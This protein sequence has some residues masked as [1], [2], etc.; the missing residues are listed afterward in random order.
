MD[1]QELITRGR[2][3]FS[4]APGRLDVFQAVNGKRN[5][6]DIAELLGRHANSIR[7]DLKMIEDAELIQAVFQSD[8]VKKKDGFPIYE[9]IPLSRTVNTRYFR[10]PQRISKPYGPVVLRPPKASEGSGSPKPLAMPS[11]SEVL[12]IARYGE[13][14]LHEFKAQGTDFSKISNEVGAFLNTQYGGMILYG[15][16]D[17]GNIEG[18]DLTRQQFDQPM[19]NSIKN[20]IDPPATVHLASV[21]V[22]G[23]EILIIII[24]PWN[25]KDVYYTKGKVLLRR[26]TNAFTAKAE[27]AKRLHDGKYVT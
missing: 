25:R 17:D 20:L 2:F 1:L 5:T 4:R 22:M 7:R 12:D 18:S 11:E 24:P 21:E 9:K 3:I 13:D 8:E 19:Q 10:E 26:G 27:E 14:Q 6:L 16:D 23:A 15:I